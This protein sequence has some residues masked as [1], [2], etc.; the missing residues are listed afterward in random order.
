MELLEGKEAQFDKM[1]YISDLVL[2]RGK[3]NQA[4]LSLSASNAGSTETSTLRA[5]IGKLWD[6][7]VQLCDKA[8]A[9]LMGM[10]NYY[11][12]RGSPI[13]GNKLQAAMIQAL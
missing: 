6:N 1:Q 8:V 4:V 13:P 2:L 5:V 12:D 7:L 11:T 3:V 9:P 10:Y